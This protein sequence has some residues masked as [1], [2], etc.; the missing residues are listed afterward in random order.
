M[1]FRHSVFALARAGAGLLKSVKQGDKILFRAE[2]REAGCRAPAPS[3][4]PQR[5]I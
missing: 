3:R 2:R 5:I 1:L 4:V